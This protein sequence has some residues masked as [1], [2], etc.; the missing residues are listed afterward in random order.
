MVSR[1]S[2]PSS[3]PQQIQTM[4]GSLLQYP[5]PRKPTGLGAQLIRVHS[6]KIADQLPTQTMGNST[7][8]PA[9]PFWSTTGTAV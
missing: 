8:A 2:G 4:P 3:F 9:S 6:N 7:F 1:V 5:W